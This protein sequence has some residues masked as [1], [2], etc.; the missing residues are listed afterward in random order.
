[1]PEKFTVTPITKNDVE[2]VKNL[3]IQYWGGDICVSRGKVQKVDDFT[4]GFIARTAE[5][6]A[7]FITYTISG[8]EL[9]I[10]NLI[11]LKENLG[12]G[13][14]LVKTVIE[15]AKKQKIKRIC[16]TTTNDNL[17]GIGF[18]QKRGF[19]LVRVYPNAMEYTRKLKP[20]IP[21]IGENG[22]PL[23]DELELEMILD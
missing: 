1:M 5:Q 4:G 12:I 15:L 13:S 11:S 21:L 20:A 9:E 2:W 22:I 3:F 6:N 18:W 10:T 7:G 17:N 8:E 23:R 19:K 16:L 14:A